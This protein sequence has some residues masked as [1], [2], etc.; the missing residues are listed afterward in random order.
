MSN[1]YKLFILQGVLLVIVL[2]VSC[3]NSYSMPYFQ[4]VRNDKL[5]KTIS[6]MLCIGLIATMFF[7]MNDRQGLLINGG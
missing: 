3:Y 7:I 5:I 1:S 6:I 2:M 4:F